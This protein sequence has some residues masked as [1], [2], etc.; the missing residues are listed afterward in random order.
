MQLRAQQWKVP[1]IVLSAI[2]AVN[3]RHKVEVPRA[4][5]SA[6]CPKPLQVSS[7][8]NFSV[9]EPLKTIAPSRRLHNG[10]EE[11]STSQQREGLAL[12]SDQR[13]GL[14][15]LCIFVVLLRQFAH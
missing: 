7:E 6:A 12:H 10:R 1:S 9:L 2:P 8:A 15:V 14:Q 13:S 3:Q 11:P 4:S 5:M